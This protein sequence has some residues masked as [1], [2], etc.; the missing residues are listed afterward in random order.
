MAFELPALPYSTNALAA[1]GMSQETLEL[2]RG[3]HHQAYVTA[4]NGFV[5]KNDD[6]KG[7]SLE[8]IIRFATGKADLAPVF[9]N[10]GQH[11]NHILFW[12]VLSPQGG[13]IP[14]TLEKKLVADFGSVDAFKEAFKT[15]A[16]TQ[17]G[18]GWAWLVLGDDGKLKVTKT[19]NADNPLAAG[20][21]R[22]L[23]GLDVW[24]HSYYVDFRN[25]RPDY[26]TNF[27]DK[28]ANYEFAEAELNK[29]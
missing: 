8:E 29:A 20:Q 14:G 11:W 28:L 4:L 12:Q 10:A 26:T 21:G 17:F 7:K 19:A 1:A 2:H 24:E 15:A 3:K 9:N 27:L 18:S 5:E 25:R 16:T 6:L 22:A 13:K 23:L